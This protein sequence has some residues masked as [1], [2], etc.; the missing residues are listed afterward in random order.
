MKGITL[1]PSLNRIDGLVRLCKSL[2]ETETTT[3]G[4]VII[5]KNDFESKKSTYVEL[6]HDYFL[7]NWDFRVGDAV[8]MGDK[9]RQVWPEIEAMNLDWVNLENDD[10][11]HITHEWDKRLSLQITGKN[12]I[13]C[14]DRWMAPKKAAGATMISMPLL[15]CWGFPIFPPGLQHLFIDDL[16]ETVGMETG[17]WDHDMSVVVEHR[18]VLKRESPMDAT[19]QKSYGK[20]SWQADHAV[21][22]KFLKDEMPKL[23]ERTLAFCLEVNL[24][25]K[26]HV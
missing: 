8:T 4:W 11:V 24:S 6:K 3:P 16:L 23:I 2:K 7:D 13:S 20:A 19:H 5:D 10:H 25:S 22:E 26:A 12:F 15:K 9:V 18:H 14:S 17:C 1:I 21:W